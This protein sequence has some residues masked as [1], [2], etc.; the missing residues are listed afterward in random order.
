MLTVALPKGRILKPL[1]AV[2]DGAGLPA[3]EA[4]A[5]AGR[6]LVVEMGPWQVLLLKDADV[7]VYVAEGVADCGVAGLD[8]VLERNLDVLRLLR[9]P[10]GHCA[11]CLVAP[12]GR[13]VRETGR[14]LV[15]ASKLPRLA[16]ELAAGKGLNARVVTLAGSV[17]L[18]A[19][20][21]LADAA[22]DLVETGQT[23]RENGLAPV[24]EWLRVAP[25]LI[26]NR[27]SLFLKGDEIRAARRTMGGTP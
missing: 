23:L 21:E 1:A 12:V 16:A 25:Y 19:R 9:L 8:Q 13:L 6:A 10:F 18:S 14:P 27:A 3:T 17:E 24:E 5:N 2:L 4:L 7:P 22:V 20:L 11:L 15:L 26:A